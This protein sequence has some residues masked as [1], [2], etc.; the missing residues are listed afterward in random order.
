MDFRNKFKIVSVE[1]F[2]PKS[3]SFHPLW[4]EYYDFD[5]LDEIE[6]W[7]IN[8]ELAF[9]ELKG[10]FSNS[11]HPYYTVPIK[12]FP[13]QRMRFFTK[14]KFKT[15]KGN[16][17]DGVVMNEGD[18]VV[19]IFLGNN[20][21]VSLSCHTMLKD[22]AIKTLLK[23]SKEFNLELSELKILEFETVI[24]KEKEKRIRGKFIIDLE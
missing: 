17:L 16:E 22:L 24:P 10:K 20:Q 7:G 8:K 11:A 21:M 15:L 5:E 6:T 9:N 1:E 3:F 19:D 4:S 13:P 2:T 23:I 14:A 18:L 12:E